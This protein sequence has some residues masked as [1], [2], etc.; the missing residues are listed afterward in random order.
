VGDRLCHQGGPTG[1]E[2]TFLHVGTGQKQGHDLAPERGPGGSEGPQAR[3]LRL[4]NVGLER[5]VR[6]QTRREVTY[7]LYDQRDRSIPPISPHLPHGSGNF[8][9][10][11][12]AENFSVTSSLS[13]RMWRSSSS[14]M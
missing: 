13:W 4:R 11:E 7:I 5:H 14:L 1:S 12:C 3:C 6:I 10:G 2:D 9:A 8:S